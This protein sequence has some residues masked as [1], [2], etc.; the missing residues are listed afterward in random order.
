MR[1]FSSDYVRIA[2]AFRLKYGEVTH[3]Q[4]ETF[5]NGY[6]AKWSGDVLNWQA[7]TQS[8]VVRE[9]SGNGPGQD[10]LDMHT[11]ASVIF[12]DRALASPEQKPALNF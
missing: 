12:L 3:T 11:G 10:G 9:G 2:E 4:A 1:Y 6:G 5:Q 7:G 8:I